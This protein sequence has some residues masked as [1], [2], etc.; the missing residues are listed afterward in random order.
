MNKLT[1]GQ[2]I[3]ICMGAVA[4]AAIVLMLN[5]DTFVLGSAMILLPILVEFFVL[6][7]FLM[8]NWNEEI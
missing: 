5:E 7:S 4:L 8:D 3:H 2:L 1:W 6:V